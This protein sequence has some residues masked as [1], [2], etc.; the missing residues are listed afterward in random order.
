MSE[1]FAPLG[2]IAFTAGLT[3]ALRRRRGCHQCPVPARLLPYVPA[4]PSGPDGVPMPHPASCLACPP[5]LCS[6]LCDSEAELQPSAG[7]MEQH[8]TAISPELY[9]DASMRRTAASWLVEVAT[10]FG[11]HQETLFLA[12]A[13]LDRFLSA[14]KAS[15]PLQA[16]KE[17][18]GRTACC[19]R[20]LAAA[21]CTGCHTPTLVAPASAACT[22][23]NAPLRCLRLRCCVALRCREC[24]ARSCSW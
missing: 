14:T 4:P 10:E 6:V 9:L 8:G 24:R 2:R 13:L 7:F 19:A 1:S 5:P 20:K 15:L 12:T 11:L 23:L 22:L 21:A 16:G 18:P 3:C 17:R